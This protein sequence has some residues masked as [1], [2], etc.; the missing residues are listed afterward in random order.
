MNETLPMIG[1]FVICRSRDQGVV[2]GVLRSCV[3]APGGAVCVVDEARQIH[4]WSD[5]ANTLFEASLKGLGSARISEEIPTI[6]MFNVCGVLPCSPTAEKNLRQSRW[7][8]PAAS[9][10]SRPT[11]TAGR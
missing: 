5:G 9:S 3:P 8:K 6:L 10:T 4:G 2:C 11:R 1:S 7:N